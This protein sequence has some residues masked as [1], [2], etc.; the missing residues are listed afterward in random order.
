MIIQLTNTIIYDTDL[1]FEK[2]T[3]ECVEFVTE[4]IINNTPIFNYDN[5][6]R[7][8]EY[9]YRT[10]DWEIVNT[11]IW[12]TEPPS[13]GIEK[14]IISVR[15]PEIWHEDNM[16]IQIKMS[17]ENNVLML[18]EYPE[19]GVYRKV[20]KINTYNLN[21]F[22]YTYVNYILPEHESLLINFGGIINYK[23]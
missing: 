21:N 19:I 23:Q 16:N 15:L 12:N 10:N 11:Q 7:P 8:F 4:Y 22:T 3:S 20:N 2:Q 13:C 17:F 6:N 9:I 18:E 14:E 1:T 5:T